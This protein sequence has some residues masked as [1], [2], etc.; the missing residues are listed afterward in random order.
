MREVAD[1]VKCLTDKIR[2]VKKTLHPF[3]IIVGEDFDNITDSSV[4]I[5]NFYY[6]D[7][8]PLRA[9]DVCF[10]TYHALYAF[11]PH[12]RAY[13]RLFLEEVAY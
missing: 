3:A 13:P 10:K 8:S 1:E 2:A 6:R 9:I 7:D 12:Q 4:Y 11:Y 5:D